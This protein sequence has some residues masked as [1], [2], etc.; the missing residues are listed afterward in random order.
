MKNI[1]KGQ[2]VIVLDVSNYKDDYSNND[3]VPFKA[4]VMAVYDN[5]IVVIS[6]DSLKK[7]ELYSHQIL[8]CFDKDAIK[9][10]VSVETWSEDGPMNN[11]YWI[12]D[13]EAKLMYEFEKDNAL[14]GVPLYP[15]FEDYLINL[16]KFWNSIGYEF[17][18]IKKKKE[19][20]NNFLK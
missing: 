16:K 10:M 11:I 18:L 5:E 1:I 17:V 15:T 19:D 3:P 12:H 2:T 14:G 4:E 6:A 13:D 8:E 7:Y 20:G 9:E